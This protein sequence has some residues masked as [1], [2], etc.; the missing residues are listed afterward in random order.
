MPTPEHAQPPS[1]HRT[2]PDPLDAWYRAAI[3]ETMRTCPEY[4][5]EVNPADP[6]EQAE[7]LARR[8]GLETLWGDD[9]LPGR[10]DGMTA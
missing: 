10:P 7:A 1:D 9:P 2:P 3:A 5:P 4:R 6:A 8:A